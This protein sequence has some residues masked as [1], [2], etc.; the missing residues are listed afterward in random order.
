MGPLVCGCHT[1]VL[2]SVVLSGVTHLRWLREVVPA[3]VLAGMAVAIPVVAAGAHAGGREHVRGQKPAAHRSG[4]ASSPFA[5]YSVSIQA[6][7]DLAGNPS[8]VANFSPNGSLAEPSWAI[9]RAPSTNRCRP[10]ATTHA[11]LEPG[12]E[13]AGTVFV[14]TSTYLGRIYSARVTWEGLVRTLVTPRVR[15]RATVGSQV[16]PVVGRWAGGWGTEFDQ[17][18]VEACRTAQGQECV[19]LSGGQLGCPGSGAGVAVGGWFTGW[20]L[21]G[22]DERSARDEACAGVAYGLPADVPLWPLGQTIAR[23]APL[24]PVTGPPAPRVSIRP[25]AL[26]RSGR[27][28]FTTLRCAASCRFWLTAS[29]HYWLSG[30]HGTITISRRVTTKL[31][32]VPRAGLR[33][34]RLDVTVNVDGGPTVDGK[35]RLP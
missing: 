31:I 11:V 2:G 28:L 22:L 1:L 9:C 18:G 33:P 12:P 10:V 13:P 8:L 23:S 7:F 14:A 17:L 6:V 19:M 4:V 21:F 26:L 25:V 16:I 20:Y 35:T 29:D 15:G 32:G 27:V 24:G 3:A 30:S 34:G 5:G